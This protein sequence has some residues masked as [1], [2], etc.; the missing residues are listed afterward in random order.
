M[1][2]FHLLFPFIAPS[3]LIIIII[4][5]FLNE[6]KRL[7]DV[8]LGTSSNR[9]PDFQKLSFFFLL[10]ANEIIKLR[11]NEITAKYSIQTLL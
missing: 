5:Y 9:Q 10:Q 4:N 2:K 7:Q 11:E 8:G 3:N 1:D 6:D